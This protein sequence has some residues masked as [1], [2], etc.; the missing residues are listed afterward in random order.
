MNGKI[1]EK[2]FTLFSFRFK[3]FDK[4]IFL[5]IFCVVIIPTFIFRAIGV[6]QPL[7]YTLYDLWYQI[8]ATE[9]I[10]E[11]III[12]EWDE[13]SI[14]KFNQGEISDRTLVELLNKIIKQKPRLIGL[15]LFRNVTNPDSELDRIENKQAWSNLATIFND[16]DNII[17]IKKIIEPKVKAHP[18]LENKERVTASDVKP[19]SDSI[20]R[21][22]YAFPSVDECGHPVKVPY[23]GWALALKYLEAEGWDLRGIPENQQCINKLEVF[24]KNEQY[25]SIFFYKSRRNINNIFDFNRGWSYLINWRKTKLSK[26]FTTISAMDVVSGNFEDYKNESLFRDRLVIIGNTAVSRGDIHITPLTR[27]NKEK[28]TFGVEIVAQAASTFI[29]AAKDE[30][31]IVESVPVWIEYV[32]SLLLVSGLALYSQVI[33]LSKKSIII[34]RKKLALICLISIILLT[35]LNFVFFNAGIW[36]YISMATVSMVFSSLF[37]NYYSQHL[38]QKSDFQKMILLVR[39]SNHNLSNVAVS[40]NEHCSNISYINSEIVQKLYKDEQDFGDGLPLNDEL[41]ADIKN[42]QENIKYIKSNFYNI[43]Y[44]KKRLKKFINYSYT[45]KISELESYNF[46]HEVEKIANRNLTRKKDNG[47][48]TFERHYDSSIGIQ[49]IYIEELEIIIENLLRNAFSAVRAKKIDNPSYT[50]HVDLYTKK[51]KN[52]LKITIKD[53]GIGI[54]KLAQKKIFDL[55]FSLIGAGDG[56]GLYLV[57]QAVE[58]WGGSISVISNEGEGASFCITLPIL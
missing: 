7:E 58:Y 46:N 17:G 1:R 4:N 5:Y 39:N 45:G 40:L 16:N 27:W 38:K 11:R 41:R 25:D 44:Y 14:E 23:I 8:K 21:Q 29:S 56:V 54:P 53:N 2:L 49:K 37:I 47:S 18:V 52:L 20:I 13:P 43:Q 6:F 24:D 57:H 35:F 31:Q 48:I 34:L 9:S 36:L 22:A 50:P 30:R 51:D 3:Q 55:E 10:D 33:L 19:D 26:N 28:R 42:V 15:D 32:L 12:V